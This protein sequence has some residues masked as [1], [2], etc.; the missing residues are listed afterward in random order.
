V[1]PRLIRVVTL[2]VV[3][4]VAALGVAVAFAWAPDRSVEELATR[5][6]PPPSTFI[7]VGEHTVHLRDE[8]PH[9]ATPPAAEAVDAATP[10]VLLHGT[11]A[12]LHTWDGWVDALV[13]THRVIRF[14]LPGFGLTGPAPDGDYRIQAYAELVLAVLDTMG[15]PRAAVAGN[16]LGGEIAARVG[17]LAPERVAALVLV[18]PAGFPLESESVPLG[19]RLA[20]NPTAARFLTSILPR[21]VVR[22]SV[23]NVYGDPSLVT[24]ELVDRYYELTLR[25][26]NR[27]ALPERFKQESNGADTVHLPRIVAPTLILWGAEDRLIPL[28]H[29][30]RW[31]RAVAGSELIVYPGLGHVPQ[32]EAASATV[33]DALRFLAR[34]DVRQRR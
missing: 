21:S 3:V 12:S 20:R 16:S 33:A 15:I 7:R 6:A 1:R 19:F 18:D 13:G 29:A 5:W 30:A 14:D 27:A 23:E 10:I 2:V 9:A 25:A 31:Q 11:S 32:E 4:A 26:G 8:G 22:S 24:D 28:A 17:S 34:S